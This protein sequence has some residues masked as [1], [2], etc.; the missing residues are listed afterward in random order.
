MRDGAH[1]P[2][3]FELDDLDSRENL[4]HE[5]RHAPDASERSPIMYSTGTSE[6]ALACR[7]T[8]PGPDA[9]SRKFGMMVLMTCIADSA[10]ASRH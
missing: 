2:Q 10:L 8:T 1:V 3:S 7:Q 5:H 9:A 6:L 4:G